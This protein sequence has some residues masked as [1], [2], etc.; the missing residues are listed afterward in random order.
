VRCDEPMA[1][2]TCIANGSAIIASHLIDPAGQIGASQ[3][4]ILSEVT[5]SAQRAF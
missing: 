2:Q 3:H 1:H 5:K 4:A